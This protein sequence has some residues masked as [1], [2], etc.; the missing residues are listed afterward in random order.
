MDPIEKSDSIR[1]LHFNAKVAQ[2]LAVPASTETVDTYEDNLAFY[3][4]NNY[5]YIPL[6]VDGQ[7]Y[8]RYAEELRALNP[9]QVIDTDT[10]LRTIFEK[11]Q[12]EPFLLL[13][14]AE[15]QETDPQST[16]DPNS[17]SDD[18]YMIITV[19]D[20][21]RRVVSENIYPLIAELE[22]ELA[23]GIKEEIESSE[24][25]YHNLPARFIGRREKDKIQDVD[26]HIVEYLGL[27]QLVQ[28]IKG[29]HNLL[30]KFGFESASECD[31]I[32]GSINQLRNRVMHANRSLIRNRDDIQTTLERVDDAQQLIADI[33]DIP[34][35]Q[36]R[37]A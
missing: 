2:R 27:T 18:R 1:G 35:S 29:R 10:G 6:P 8:D 26:L 24:P 3:A 20:L 30:T 15:D 17:P 12:T 13:D 11:L 5:Q 37:E 9:T 21:N 34:V 23:V 32:V 25:L 28:I 36:I 16:D 33:H 7:Y 22:H 4:E 19:A 14:R 31:D